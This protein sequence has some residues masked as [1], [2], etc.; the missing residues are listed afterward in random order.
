M[1]SYTWLRDCRTREPG[2]IGDCT[3]ARPSRSFLCEIVKDGIVWRTRH[4]GRCSRKA[5][6]QFQKEQR[7]SSISF[8]KGG[9]RRAIVVVRPRDLP[10]DGQSCDQW[11]KWYA[12]DPDGSLK[13]LDVVY[14]K[15]EYTQH[16]PSLTHALWHRSTLLATSRLRNEPSRSS[17]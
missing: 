14:T 2:M 4:R 12:E 5:Q 13:L 8:G 15:N 11:K 6:V 16:P 17:R 10:V 3:R 1:I 7:V 9:T